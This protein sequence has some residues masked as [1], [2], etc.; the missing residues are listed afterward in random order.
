M[1]GRAYLCTVT[2][3]IKYTLYMPPCKL[4]RVYTTWEE[5]DKA[6]EHWLA[7]YNLKDSGVHDVALTEIG[8]N[9]KRTAK[10]EPN[11]SHSP[12]SH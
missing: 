11:A 8:N 7:L 9:K 6:Y 3:Y 5:A 1:S 4:E 10:G 12:V 2:V